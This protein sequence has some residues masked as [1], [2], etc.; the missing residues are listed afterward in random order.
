MYFSPIV[1]TNTAT[2]PTCS[3][4]SGTNKKEPI[5]LLDADVTE[6]VWRNITI[7]CMRASEETEGA[8]DREGMQYALATE[9]ASEAGGLLDRDA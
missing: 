6:V 1:A 7:P 8:E 5:S 4:P 3:L 9:A 2:R